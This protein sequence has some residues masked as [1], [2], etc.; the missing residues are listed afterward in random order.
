MWVGVAVADVRIGRSLRR[1]TA[2]TACR[3][4]RAR[5]RHELIGREVGEM[6]ELWEEAI[7]WG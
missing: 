5:L 4:V 2:Y 1:R 3:G 7:I 6:N